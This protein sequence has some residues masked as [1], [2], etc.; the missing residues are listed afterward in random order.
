KQTL[1]VTLDLTQATVVA[2][3]LLDKVV[4][5]TSFFLKSK[6]PFIITGLG[7]VGVVTAGVL[8]ARATRH[9][10]P[11][12]DAHKA[13][14]K[15]ARLNKAKEIEGYSN[16]D[17]AKS[18]ISIYGGTSLKLCRL[19]G[20][21]VTLGAISIAAIVTGHNMQY[22]RFVTA[23]TAL[24]GSEA[25]FAEYRDQ[26]SK[27]LGE[28]AENDLYRGIREE[29]VENEE[30]DKEEIKKY[31]TDRP[32]SEYARIFGPETSP[33]WHHIATQND[34]IVNGALDYFN[35]RLN[36]LGYVL[37]SEVYEKLG[38]K[39]TQASRM[40]GWLKDGK[41]GEIKFNPQRFH[42]D[43]GDIVLLLDFN[44]DGIILTA[45]PEV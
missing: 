27:V 41:D 21:S 10:D 35:G 5:P 29:V 14:V 45:L 13:E 1:G 33:Q 30:T 19:Y 15:T 36:R 32:V 31:I 25:A 22:K 40:V 7:I 42:R 34:Y 26:V 8:A 4:G 39:V 3:S 38:F 28:E 2:P 23:A 11:I 16:T 12:V 37:L 9:L 44:V 43:N 17:H 20:S 24:K 18:L 6:A